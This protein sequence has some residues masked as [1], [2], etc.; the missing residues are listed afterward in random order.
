MMLTSESSQLWNVGAS[1]SCRQ[2]DPLERVDDLDDGGARV[3]LG[4]CPAAEQRL[5]GREIGQD[6]GAFRIVLAEVVRHACCHA[7]EDHV[8]GSAQQHDRVEPRVE[9]PLVGDAARDEEDAV[10]VPEELVDPVLAP[11]RLRPRPPSIQSP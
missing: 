3:D 10:L 2:G 9:L 11:E 6:P 1:R 5:D 7:L 4:G 8:G